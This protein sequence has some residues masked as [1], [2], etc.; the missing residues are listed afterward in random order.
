MVITDN[1]ITREHRLSLED[2]GIR[3]LVA[4]GVRGGSTPRGGDS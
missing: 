2:K 4:E 1:G 3:V